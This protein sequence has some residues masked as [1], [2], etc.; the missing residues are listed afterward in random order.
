MS[1]TTK[2]PAVLSTRND[3]EILSDLLRI[4]QAECIRSAE[5][6]SQVGALNGARVMLALAARAYELI[7]KFTGEN[8]DLL[9]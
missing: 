2:P 7:D 4:A 6:L 5:E 3:A 9:D 1:D 8:N